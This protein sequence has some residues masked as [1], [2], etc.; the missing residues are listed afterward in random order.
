[1]PMVIVGVG[2]VSLA[3]TDIDV[4]LPPAEVEPLEVEGK[5][6]LPLNRGQAQPC[7][8]CAGIVASH[9]ILTRDGD[10]EDRGVDGLGGEVLDLD[11]QGSAALKLGDGQA[12]QIEQAYGDDLEFQRSKAVLV[13]P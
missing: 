5:L 8:C 12:F 1:M 13:D 6:P 7:R 2:P 9:P 10:A 4:V 3:H 11:A